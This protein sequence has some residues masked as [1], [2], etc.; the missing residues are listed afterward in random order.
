DGEPQTGTQQGE[1][2]DDTEKAP[3]R[4]QRRW[5]IFAAGFGDARHHFLASENAQHAAH[6][7][8]DRVVVMDQ[9]DAD[10]ALP[11]ILPAW[12]GAGGVSAG[13]RA[14][15]G[16]APQR[17]RGFLAVADIEPEK[18]TAFRAEETEPAREHRFRDVEFP[19][20]ERAVGLD[21]A[22]LAPQ[23]DA[24]L[25]YRQRH[26]RA[27]IGAQ[28]REALDQPRI[29]GNEAAAQPRRARAFG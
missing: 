28:M 14:Q 11:G 23:R 13:Q 4:V 1:T 7:R 9:R 25:L 19:A 26:L 17:Q 6:A 5:G 27:G 24:R 2:E 20:I 21:M 18:K 8:G 16:V 12:I 10:I 29:A 15:G 3:P 22:L